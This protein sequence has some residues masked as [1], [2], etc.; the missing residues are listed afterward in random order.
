[1]LTERQIQAA[2]R[3]VTSE[4]VLNDGAAGRG[5][6]S[7]RL[8]IRAGAK[9]PNATWQAVWWNAGKQTSKALGRYPDL[10]LADARRKYETEVRDVLTAGRDPNAVVAMA[11]TPT[12]EKLFQSYIQ[13]LRDKETATTHTSEHL[14][15]T[16]KY[17]AADLLG[18]NTIAST[19]EPADIANVLAKGVK[20]GARRTTDMQRTAMMA[21]FN[22]AMKSTHDYTQE[23]RMDWGLKYNPVAA[24]PRDQA[25]NRTLDRNLSAEEMKHV[26]D[27]APE[28]SGDV[29]RLVMC[30]GQRV[31]EV[32]R[33]A[34]AD[35]DL[36]ARLWTMPARKTKGRKQTHMVPLTT[37]AVDILATL[38]DLYGDGYL[39]P[40]RAGAKGDIIGI[41]SVSRGA[42]RMA[43][44]KPF[45]PR[46]LRRTWKSRAG[47][48]G[49]DRFTRDL[50][51]QHAQTDTGSKHYDRFDYLPQMRDAMTKWEAWLADALK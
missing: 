46:D 7:L 41:P 6:G 48:A 16:G 4:T 13:Y 37:Q 32:M 15:L 24:V 25:A 10:S 49:I 9:G 43:G 50:I 23:N 22:W 2:M 14:L 33:I 44:I 8:R 47:D 40:A 35:V 5:S 12:I 18:R 11:E 45:T 30:T 42:S 36:K 1:M 31:I 39:F 26:W 17:N 3:A 19:I 51:Q 20:R 34:G 21:A 28:Q 27:N 38:I 29:M